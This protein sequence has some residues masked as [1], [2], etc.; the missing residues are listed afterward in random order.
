M[1]SITN[2]VN[3]QQSAMPLVAIAAAIILCV[4][5]I[6]RAAKLWKDAERRKK[7]AWALACVAASI[8]CAAFVFASPA[9][10]I[11]WAL[12]SCVLAFV[13]SVLTNEVPEDVE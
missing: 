6:A 2:V 10:E 5:V 9:A 7:C 4:W 13:G 11:W 3:I 1:E 8:V 12:A